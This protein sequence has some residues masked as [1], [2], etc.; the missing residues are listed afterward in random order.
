[1]SSNVRITRANARSFAQI[2][3][4]RT[5]PETLGE[6]L[7]DVRRIARILSPAAR[8]INAGVDVSDIRNLRREKGEIVILVRNSAQHTKLRQMLPRLQQLL[9]E[10]GYR[11]ALKLRINP[12]PQ[13]V[14]VRRDTLSGAP[15]VASSQSIDIIRKKAESMQ[16]SALK[17]ALEALARTMDKA[18]NNR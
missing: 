3:L 7:F 6:E 5:L 14:V 18:R 4:D 11:D 8:K 12:A 1:M 16:P 2:S 13:P 15:R 17:N 10:A 9:Q